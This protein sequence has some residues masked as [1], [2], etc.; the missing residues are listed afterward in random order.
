MKKTNLLKIFSVIALLSTISIGPTAS[1]QTPSD[2]AKNFSCTYS[3]IAGFA[4]SW[5]CDVELSSTPAGC[6]YKSGILGVGAGTVCTSLTPLLNITYCRGGTN[7][8]SA[9]SCGPQQKA[10]DEAVVQ[11]LNAK[12]VSGKANCQL[13][14]SYPGGTKITC[15]PANIAGCV[16]SRYGGYSIC[17]NYPPGCGVTFSSDPSLPTPGVG[18]AVTSCDIPAGTQVQSGDQTPT[19][20]GTL[21]YSPLEPLPGL[22]GIENVDFAT[23]LNLLFKVL[24]TVGALFAVG[25]LVWGGIMYMASGATGEIG[26]AKKRMQAAIYGLLLLAGSWLILNTINPQL[27]NFNISGIEGGGGAP[28]TTDNS[29]RNGSRPSAAE[30]NA[31]ISGGGNIRYE[32]GG[33]NCE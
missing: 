6:E 9:A 7:V 13:D 25:M 2:A 16:P 31:C 3:S 18:E 21:E 10:L 8:G 24:I 22:E 19:T 11:N 30:K 26:E 27:L 1:A 4:G 33:W 23:M 29:I 17:S 5:I 15:L 28:G 32:P 12:A 20:N 14:T